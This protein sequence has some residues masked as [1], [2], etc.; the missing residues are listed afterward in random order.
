M[1]GFTTG[2]MVVVA[3]I[4][5]MLLLVLPFWFAIQ[6]LSSSGSGVKSDLSTYTTFKVAEL[7]HGEVLKATPRDALPA[8]QECSAHCTVTFHEHALAVVDVSGPQVAFSYK[9]GI[10]TLCKQGTELVALLSNDLEGEAPVCAVLSE[11][12]KFSDFYKMLDIH[13]V[14][15]RS[16]GVADLKAALNNLLLK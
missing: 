2:V 12:E 1:D 10:C 15:V 4:L 9:S 7:C 13:S 16:G 3:S 8:F 6:R 5:A 11:T 14:Q